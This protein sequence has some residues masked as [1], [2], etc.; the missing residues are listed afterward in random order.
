MS[1][2]VKPREMA[3]Q[4]GISARTLRDWQA[5]RIIPFIKIHQTV[6]F[7]PEKVQAALEKFERKA[8]A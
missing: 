7:E 2:K 6:L 1:K 8:V 3:A 5:Q 4:L